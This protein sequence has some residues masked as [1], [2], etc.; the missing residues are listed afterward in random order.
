[1]NRF[2][3]MA[4]AASRL[5]DA[6]PGLPGIA[7]ITIGTTITGTSPTQFRPTIAFQ[8]LADDVAGMSAWATAFTA[9][10]R[11]IR[12]YDYVELSTETV[13]EGHTVVVWDHL[14]VPAA[15]ALAARLG[16]WLD[17]ATGSVLD[18][19]PTDLD[20]I[21]AHELARS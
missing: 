14:D 15:D 18:I 20:A 11:L 3:D 21:R 9:S 6:H 2:S 12:K 1:M 10:V 13:H 19:D 7:S 8:M 16:C 4:A 17:S 5:L